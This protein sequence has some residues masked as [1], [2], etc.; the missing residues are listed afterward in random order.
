MKKPQK[1]RQSKIAAAR[2]GFLFEQAKFGFKENPEQSD[3]FIKIARRIAMKYRIRLNSRQKKSFCKE[4]GRF[5]VPGVNCRVRV[6]KGR[7]IYFCQ[8]CEK[9]KRHPIK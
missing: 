2:I 5:L 1:S 6:H 4:C 7:V 8:K 3:Y 9:I